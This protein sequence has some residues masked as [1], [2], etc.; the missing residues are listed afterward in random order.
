MD[1]HYDAQSSQSPD[2]TFEKIYEDRS[3][4]CSVH[5]RS[6]IEINSSRERGIKGCHEHSEYDLFFRCSW[7]EII[8]LFST[9]RANFS[10]NPANKLSDEEIL[11]QLTYVF[12]CHAFLNDSLF[13]TKE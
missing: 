8:E 10:E 6:T 13:V 5:F 2:A 4:S 1:S 7:N 9:V 3:R 11:C 12:S